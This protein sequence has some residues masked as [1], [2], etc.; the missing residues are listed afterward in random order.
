MGWLP[1]LLPASQG[2]PVPCLLGTAPP[3]IQSRVPASLRPPLASSGH[4]SCEGKGV[5]K[6][7]PGPQ[8]RACLETPRSRGAL[9]WLCSP[10]PAGASLPASPLAA[11]A[12]AYQGQGSLTVTC[13]QFSQQ[14][15]FNRAC[16]GEQPASISGAAGGRGGGRALGCSQ[17]SV[18][19]HRSVA[20]KAEGGS[21]WGPGPDP[22]KPAPGLELK[23]NH[24]A[25]S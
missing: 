9:P 14:V 21:L 2:A 24:V 6:T 23:G 1:F 25:Q 4:G 22:E 20:A 18:L 7:H 16:Q 3:V 12:L 11:I 15:T 17:D 5:P 19:S 8:K 10:L 13:F